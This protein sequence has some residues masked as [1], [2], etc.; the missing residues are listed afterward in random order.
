MTKDNTLN[1]FSISNCSQLRFSYRLMAVSVEGGKTEGKDY[2]TSFNNAI[3]HMASVTRGVVSEA[4]YDHKK[5]IAVRSDAELCAITLVGTPLDVYLEPVEQVFQF[6]PEDRS[7]E[8]MAL[9]VRFLENAIEFQL[10]RKKGLWSGGNNSFLKKNPTSNSV[11]IQT[12]IYQGFKYRVHQQNGEFFVCVDLAYRYADKNTLTEILKTLPKEQWAGYVLGQS[13]L[14]L[15]GD[16]WYTVKGSA[17]GGK[18]GE[19]PFTKDDFSGTI[20][21]YITTKGLYAN[22][23]EPPKLSKD[24]LTF[25]HTYTKDSDK[26][27]EGAADLAKP[28]TLAEDGL[29]R[30]SINQPH[31]R[32][33][34]AEF[35]VQKY[36]QNFSFAGIKLAIATVPFIQQCR[37]IDFPALKYAN[38]H[39]LDPYQAA[40]GVHGA[41]LYLFPK[42][43]RKFTYDYGLLNEDEY[44]SQY[45]F[46]PDTMPFAMQKS[47]KYYF[48]RAMMQLDKTFRGFELMTYPMKQRPFAE[49]VCREFEAMVNAKQ[50][51][52][53]YGLFVLPQLEGNNWFSQ[54]LHK[55]VK[56]ELFD[57]I[58]LKCIS[59]KSL[60]RYMRSA[61]DARGAKIYDVPDHKM[62]DFKSYQVNTLFKYLVVN[63]K[64]PYALA[65]NLNYDLYIGIDAH[66][67]YAGFCFLFKNGEKIV[68]D[69]EKTAKKAGNTF[70][71]EKV[72][73]GLIRDKIVEVL[74]RHLDAGEEF[75]KSIVVLRDGTSWGEEQKALMAAIDKLREDGKIDQSE[76]KLAVLDVAKS[77]AIPI[78]AAVPDQNNMLDNADAG[79][80]VPIREGKECYIFNTG[81]PYKI[82]GSSNPIRVSLAW[83]DIDFDKAVDDVFAMTQLN[84]TAP[85][86]AS[87][88]PLPLKLI[89]L[90]IRDVAHEYTYANVQAKEYKLLQDTM[91][92]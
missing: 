85:D 53:S 38:G 41:E 81:F 68:F 67:F 11:D 55:L 57:T 27:M 46:V 88:L 30:L 2:N 37:I 5:Y 6:D 78:R 8:N 40:S 47:I 35:F 77:S 22:A 19:Q 70:R 7:Y 33:A 90:I 1:W 51:N 82:P 91:E 80:V 45:I 49:K 66:E 39:I 34:S 52:G 23:A 61:M 18:I 20:Y 69:I 75:P 17:I 25:Y 50:L 86:R 48:N 9:A 42:R 65:K 3:K 59:E 73:S 83:G 15:N 13:F 44:M 72:N 14:Y 29:H 71:T 54:N 26:K 36:F 56:K 43:R 32:F 58:N 31:R 92:E 79:T 4:W 60:K 74:S 63:R 64:W 12:D 21:D 16:E 89:D 76:V 24:S 84:F 10:K 28:I 87:S 62:Q